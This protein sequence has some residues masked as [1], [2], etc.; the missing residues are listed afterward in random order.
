MSKW[1][2]EA[3]LSP[4]PPR[5]HQASIVTLK[6]VKYTTI[7]EK[8]HLLPFLRTIHIFHLSDYHYNR[9][10]CAIKI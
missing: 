8:R 6:A 3:Y 9:I 10:I 4:M 5:L 1:L 7:R 2:L